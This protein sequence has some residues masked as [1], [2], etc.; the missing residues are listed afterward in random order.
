VSPQSHREY[1]EKKI[2]KIAFCVFCLLCGKMF[3]N[4]S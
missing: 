3:F 4:I 2:I 1:V